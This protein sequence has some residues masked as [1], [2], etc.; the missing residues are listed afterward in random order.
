MACRI[1]WHAQESNSSSYGSQPKTHAL[2][3]T[4]SKCNNSGSLLGSRECR[5]PGLA[6]AREQ[7]IILRLPRHMLQMKQFQQPPS[8]EGLPQGLPAASSGTPKKAIHNPTA[9]KTHALTETSSK[10]NNSSSL[11]GS[12]VCRRPRLTRA[13]EQFI[14]LRLPRHM[15]LPKLLPSDASNSSSLLRSRD[16]R[17]LHLA[18]PREQFIILRLPRHMLLP[19]LLP[20]DWLVAG[21]SNSSS[22][23]RS[24]DFRTQWNRTHLLARPKDQTVSRIFNIS[25]LPRAFAMAASDEPGNVCE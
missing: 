18:R 14:I 2:T 1:I 5:R 12:R 9:P 23:L 24:R 7:F 13:R 22:L 4:S 21:A 20:S 8:L 19:K 16:C 17:M 10:C 3:E 25:S 6:R 15:L 11:L